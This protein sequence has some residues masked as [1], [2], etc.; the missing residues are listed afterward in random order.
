MEAARCGAI[1]CQESVVKKQITHDL[2]PAPMKTTNVEVQTMADCFGE[3][4]EVSYGARI[5]GKI[6]NDQ[7]CDDPRYQNMCNE[8]IDEGR[9]IEEERC[10]TPE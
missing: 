6:V 5:L 7:S 4:Q 2:G 9:I 8:A 1:A 10:S 3:M